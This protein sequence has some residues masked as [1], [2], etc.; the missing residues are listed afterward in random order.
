MSYA[1]LTGWALVS[2]PIGVAAL[3]SLIV[4][5]IAFGH[6]PHQEWLLYDDSPPGKRYDV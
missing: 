4:V 2:W 5:R 1:G 6:I 3:V